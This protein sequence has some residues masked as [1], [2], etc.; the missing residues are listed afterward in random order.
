MQAGADEPAGRWGDKLQTSAGSQRGN[1][2]AIVS[3]FVDLRRRRA[4]GNAL[5]GVPAVAGAIESDL[6]A[7]IGAAGVGAGKVIGGEDP[8]MQGIDEDGWRFQVARSDHRTLPGLPA[9][10]GVK[11]TN[12]RG[13]RAAV[14][15]RLDD[16]GNQGGMKV[17]GAGFHKTLPYS[18]RRKAL[19][20][21]LP[22]AAAVGGSQD[23]IGAISGNIPTD[24]PARFGVEIG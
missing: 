20:H 1:P 13:L 10:A 12:T 11:D 14:I 24:R 6:T 8:A 21:R 15:F 18:L 19:Q 16:S 17:G 22:V 9:I 4:A 23:V 3:G 2:I 5:P 7:D